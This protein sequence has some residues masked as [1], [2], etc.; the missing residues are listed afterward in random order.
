MTSEAQKKA[1]L[2][3]RAAHTV[4]VTVELNKSTDADILEKLGSV[5][6]KAGYIKQLIREDMQK[7]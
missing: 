7:S 5:P 3:Y 2:K 6:N 1:A 4:K